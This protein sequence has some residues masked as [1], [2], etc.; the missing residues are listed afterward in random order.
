MYKVMG[1]GSN[2][3]QVQLT[4]VGQASPDISPD[5]YGRDAKV[6]F[7]VLSNLPSGTWDRVLYQMLKLRFEAANPDGP[8][9]AAINEILPIMAEGF[10]IT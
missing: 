3:F 8:L 7:D 5:K 1:H 9:S 2:P 4:I 10:G 6:V